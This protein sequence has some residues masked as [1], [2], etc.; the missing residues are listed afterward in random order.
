[1]FPVPLGDPLARVESVTIIVSGNALPIFLMAWKSVHQCLLLFPA[2]REALVNIEPRW[3]S[4]TIRKLKKSLDG[5]NLEIVQSGLL[6]LIRP[7][8]SSEE[9]DV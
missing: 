1:M 6:K 7:R 2:L 4:L 8:V 3:S 5:F 9:G